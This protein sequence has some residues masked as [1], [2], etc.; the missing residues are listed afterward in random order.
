MPRAR[1]CVEALEHDPEKW[2]PVFGQRSCSNKGIERDDDSKKSH[3]ALAFG[4]EGLQC[5]YFRP[6]SGPGVLLRETS[7]PLNPIP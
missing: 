5:F 1:V 7:D 6:G 2:M 3:L 4:H